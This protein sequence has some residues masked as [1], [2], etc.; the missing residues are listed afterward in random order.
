MYL[1][2]TSVIAELRRVDRADRH[3]VAWAR[4]TPVPAVFMSAVS[5]L[6]IELGAQSVARVDAAQGA[7]LRAWIDG[8]LVAGFK[9]RILAVDKAVAQRCAQLYLPE[10]RQ[11]RDALIA[12]TALVHGLTVVTRHPAAFEAM[13]AALVNPWDPQPAANVGGR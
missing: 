7:A 12:A 1:L 5:I 11:Q 13:G 3:V 8:Q 4:A 9:G 10:P 6:E 2:D